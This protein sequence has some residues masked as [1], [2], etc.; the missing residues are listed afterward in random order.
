MT[1]I[2]WVEAATQG[3]LLALTAAALGSGACVAWD[4]LLASETGSSR[5]AVESASQSSDLRADP[6]SPE[7]ELIKELLN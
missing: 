3:A 2:D 5:P 4:I 6:H 1:E 7:T